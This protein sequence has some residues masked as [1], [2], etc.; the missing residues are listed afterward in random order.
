MFL[1]K[2]TKH[3]PEDRKRVMIDDYIKKMHRSRSISTYGPL[4][5]GIKLTSGKT[6]AK[7]IDEDIQEQSFDYFRQNFDKNSNSV[8]EFKFDFNSK[9]YFLISPFDISKGKFRI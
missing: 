9:A 7:K 6:K 3:I 8:F 1:T 2:E 4:L 5:K